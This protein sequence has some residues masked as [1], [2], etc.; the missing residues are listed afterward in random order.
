MAEFQRL[1]ASA[2]VIFSILK[3]LYIILSFA[4]IHFLFLFLKIF[5]WFFS[6]IKFH[7]FRLIGF[8]Q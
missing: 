5:F 7:L 3:N 6:Y 4:K 8:L 2:L 1:N